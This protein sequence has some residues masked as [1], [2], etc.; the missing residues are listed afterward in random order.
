MGFFTNS[1][2]GGG[3]GGSLADGDYGDITVSGSGSTMTLD[4][5]TNVTPAA[6]DEI[7]IKDTSD[8][9]STKSVTISDIFNLALFEADSTTGTIN[10]SSSDRG[11]L[12]KL[13][14]SS[15]SHSINLPDV[16]SAGEGFCLGICVDNTNE[17]IY[18]WVYGTSSQNINNHTSGVPIDPKG[19]MTLFY[20]DGTQWFSLRCYADPYGLTT[21]T[22]VSNSYFSFQ[23]T[24]A[25]FTTKK[26]TL[27]NLFTEGLG[28]SGSVTEIAQTFLRNDGDTGTGN[29]D[30]GGATTFEIPNNTSPSMA[31]DGRIAV[32]TSVTDFSHGVLKYYGGEEMGVVSMPIA[33]FTS[34][35][36]GAVP[37]YNATNDEF[38]MAVPSGGGGSS[39]NGGINFAGDGYIVHVDAN[40]GTTTSPTTNRLEFHPICIEKSQTYTRIGVY[41]STA[42]TSG[43]D[44]RLGIFELDSQGLPG[45]VVV[46]AGTVDTSTTGTKEITI[47]ETLQGKYYLGVVFNSTASLVVAS[48]N[49][50]GL[51][52][53]AGFST[54]NN[55][56]DT[57]LFLDSFHDATAAF[58][59]PAGSTSR[60]TTGTF[61]RVWVRVA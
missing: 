33:E 28:L 6:D 48:I 18:H 20:C 54:A 17:S 50:E 57:T 61:S 25:G 59:D 32:D 39:S 38:E 9:N 43:T 27:S 42:S 12:I 29:Y 41:V 37:T 52:A 23:E 14:N 7:V 16:S 5:P 2:G 8:S 31:A 24:T 22:P 46:D 11:K 44:G 55:S 60:T 40:G 56:S 21:G 13:T 4:T 26:V 19:G 3:G 36:D 58:N 51:V 34:P 47:S 35:T 30:F 15:S 10:L 53:W 1:G 49:T 45:N